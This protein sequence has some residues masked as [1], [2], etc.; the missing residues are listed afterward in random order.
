MVT[1]L[2]ESDA[3][4]ETDTRKLKKYC[5]YSTYAF[6][7]W[8]AT[9]RI[10]SADSERRLESRYICTYH[11]GLLTCNNAFC[12][13]ET[14]LSGLQSRLEHIQRSIIATPGLVISSSSSAQKDLSAVSPYD[15]WNGHSNSTHSPNIYDMW[16]SEGDDDGIWPL[17]GPPTATSSAHSI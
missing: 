17:G 11:C 12:L 5:V 16:E 10:K 13:A 7:R 15:V 1:Y 8:H 2:G 3:A 4:A 9:Q 14:M 6:C